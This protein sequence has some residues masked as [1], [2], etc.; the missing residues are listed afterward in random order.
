MATRA[1]ELSDLGN[2][3]HL[4][5]HDDGTVT[6]EGGNVGIGVIDPDSAL[7]VQSASSGNNSLHI[8]NTSSTGYG[9]KFLGGGNTATRYIADFRNYSGVSKVKIDGDGNV[10]IG[11][12]T[13][14]TST[15]GTNNRF[16]EVSAGTNNGSG[17]LV[18]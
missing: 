4:N 11:T 6:L 15:L 14:T 18:L 12:T 16:L 13:I 8:A 7:E 17:T 5:V 3:G 1:K 10:G 9:A 2:S